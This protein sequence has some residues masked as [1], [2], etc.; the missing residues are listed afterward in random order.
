VTNSDDDERSDAELLIATADDPE[1]FAVFYTRNFTP[2]IAF[3]WTRTRSRHDASDLTAET[4]AAALESAHRY[5]PKM[6]TPSQWLYGIANNKLKRF[7]RYNQASDRARRRLQIVTPPTATTGWEAIE[8]ADARIDAEGLSAALERL[9][10]KLRETVRLRVI[11]QLDYAVIS[12]RLG[13]T[14][15]A[16]RV[17]V[18]R[19]LR[20]L[21]A[22]FNGLRH[23]NRASL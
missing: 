10:V 13:C 17:R 6:G 22:E 1:A 16:A 3:F 5:N 14:Q 8:A 2:L 4:F 7:W 15:G 23:Q 11:E 20:R 18:L 12:D 21:E 9:P 19:G